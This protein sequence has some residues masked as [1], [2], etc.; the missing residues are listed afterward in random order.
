M[1]ITN[2]IL[3]QFYRDVIAQYNV[4]A[5]TI[6]LGV[7]IDL[8][9]G[10]LLNYV[11]LLFIDLTQ[12]TVTRET[13]QIII[14][15]QGSLFG[16]PQNIE[17]IGTDVNSSIG[18]T[19][20]C[21]SSGSV[22]LKTV[23]PGIAGS[24][25]TV[26]GFIQP[27]ESIFYSLQFKDAQW[28]ITNIKPSEGIFYPSKGL[29]LK[30]SASSATI[31]LLAKIITED[32]IIFSGPISYIKNEPTQLYLDSYFHRLTIDCGPLKL[33]EVHYTVRTSYYIEEPEENET[34]SL[35][36][37]IVSIGETNPIKI[38]V[39]VD[40]QLGNNRWIFFSDI[41]EGGLTLA[42]G[43]NGIAEFVGGN[44]SNFILPDSVR[45]LG[46]FGLTK[47][48][49]GIDPNNPSDVS[50]VF[51]EVGS[52][53]KWKPPIP[54]ISIEDLHVQWQI[55]NPFETESQ[56]SGGVGGSLVFGE[57]NPVHLDVFA[58]LPDFIIQANLRE[59]ETI[60]LV[61][62]VEVFFPDAGDLKQDIIIDELSILAD[63]YSQQ[64]ELQAEIKPDPSF[65]IDLIL[66]TL[67]LNYVSFNLNYD[68]NKLYG[69]LLAK[70][71][72]FDGDW[73]VSAAYVQPGNWIFSVRL[74]QG[75][76]VELIKLA[77]KFLN[78]KSDYIPQVDITELY[79]L[80]NLSDK[81]YTFEGEV[82]TYWNLKI[83]NSGP[84]ILAAISISSFIQENTTIYKGSISGALM[85][86][87][88][89][90]TAS[91]SFAPDTRIIQ[92][93]IKYKQLELI[94]SLLK[95]KVGTPEEKNFL[96][97]NFGDL[98]FG[99]IVEYLIGLA[100]PNAEFKLEAPWNVLNDV[101]FKNLS[102]TVDINTKSVSIDYAINLNLVFVNIN[103]IGLIYTKKEGKGKVD[104]KI[105]GRL[106][107][108]TYGDEN[109]ITWDLLDDPPPSVPAKES[110]LIELKYLGIGQHVAIDNPQ[111]FNNVEEV[112]GAL[113]EYMQPIENKD[114][115]PLTQQHGLKFDE[116]SHWL[117]G[118]DIKVIE[119]VSLSI[120]FN[121]PDLYGLL[122]A[123][124]GD[125]AGSLGGLKFEVLYVKVTEN[126]GVFKI[127]LRVPEAFRQLEFG[128]VS[129]TLPIIKLEIYTNGN[130][131]VDLGFPKN[132]DFSVSFCIQVFP[133]I[134]Y[135]GFYI[136]SLTGATSKRVPQINNG[137]F[138]PVIEFGF[139]LSVGVGKTFNKG[140][141]KAGLSVTVEGILE[142]CLAWFN[143]DDKSLP[144]PM[145][146]WMQGTIAIV[147]KLYGAVDFKI[148]KV[149]VSV[150]AY[151]SATLTIEVYEP[152]FIELKVGVEVRATVKVL[153]IK[154]HFSFSL[155]LETSFTIGHE[156]TPPWIVGQRIVPPSNGASLQMASTNPLPIAA[157]Q[158]QLRMQRS[159][160]IPKRKRNGR[161]LKSESV[162]N[163][164]AD[165]GMIAL[166]AMHV[167]E[168]GSLQWNTG[169]VFNAIKQV[170]LT[171][172]PGFTVA[173]PDTLLNGTGTA[174][175]VQISMAL[176]AENTIPLNAANAAE[177][178]AISTGS[179]TRATKAE[180]APFNL[181]IRGMLAYAINAL[182]RHDAALITLEDLETLYEL[183]D[184]QEA[185]NEGF[186]YDKLKTFISNNYSFEISGIPAESR[187][188]NGVTAATTSPQESSATIFPMIPELT[189]S[190]SGL[191]TPI[192][193]TDYHKVSAEYEEE[194]AAY[195]AHLSVDYLS[196][197]ATD[198]LDKSGTSSS[199]D[200]GNESLATMV[201]RDYFWMIAKS[202][203]QEAQDL[204]KTYAY[205]VLENQS[206]VD[207]AN[208]TDF[209]R[210]D[211]VYEVKL[212]DS[213][214]SIAEHYSMTDAEIQQL[215]PSII[216]PVNKLLTPPL[217]VNVLY[218]VTVEEIAVENQQHNLNIGKVLS[219]SG[220]NYQVRDG[221]SL[222]SITTKF[223]FDDGGILL[224]AQ[225]ADTIQLFQIG[226]TIQIAGLDAGNTTTYFLYTPV[227]G[228]T[229]QF[230]ASYFLTR[231]NLNTLNEEQWSWYIQTIA[232]FN[233]TVNFNYNPN[234]GEVNP[235]LP[236]TSL[237]IPK[238]YNNSKSDD[239]LSYL[240]RGMDTIELIAGYFTL[241][242]N[243]TADVTQLKIDIDGLNPGGII[244][245]TPA[246]IPAID[247]PIQGADTFHS[248]AMRFGLTLDVLATVNKDAISLL[249]PLAVLNIPTK[250]HTILA[251][252][253]LA[254]LAAN[255]NITV[256]EL[257]I[258]IEKEK[259][260]FPF[261]TAN[262][263][264]NIPNVPQLEVSTLE[265]KIVSNGHSNKI[266]AMVSRFLLHGLRLPWSPSG[267][268]TPES[269]L[270]GIYNLSGQQFPAPDVDTP[271]PF[272]I[273]FTNQSVAPWIKF[274]DSYVIQPGD[275]KVSLVAQFPDIENL[276]P[277]IDWATDLVAGWIVFTN[278]RTTPNDLELVLDASYLQAHYPST[279]FKPDFIGPNAMKLFN[280]HPRRYSLQAHLHWQTPVEIDFPDPA[281]SGTP[282]AGEP[283]IWFYP[284]SLQGKVES[285]AFGN[286][287]FEL[288]LFSPKVKDGNY[289]KVG[290]YMWASLI[291]FQIRLVADPLQTGNYLSNT[292]EL[293]GAPNMEADRLEALWTYVMDINNN[294]ADPA[295]YLLYPPNATSGNPS[296]LI[297]D[298]I[299]NEQTFLLKTNL[300]T[301]T[302]S[303]A[304][305]A[306]LT[307]G[308]PTSGDYYAN[309]NAPKVFMKYLWEG[310][311]VKEGGY[312]LHYT[313]SLNGMGF[314]SSTFNES[315][316]ATIQLA[317]IL[318]SQSKASN[319]L[320]A[321]KTFNNCAVIGDNMNPSAINIFAEAIGDH[322]LIRVASVPP[323]NVG[324]E[325][326]CFL[327]DPPPGT[328]PTAIEKTRSLFS[329]L[330]Y[331]L[332][333]NNL[334][335]AS[336][337]GL[338]VGPVEPNYSD[339][340]PEKVVSDS[341]PINTTSG[342][343]HHILPVAK[344]A[345]SHQL[346]ACVALPNPM[347]DP[348]AGIAIENGQLGEVSLGF[349]FHGI[350][351]NKTTIDPTTPLKNLSLSVGYNDTVIGLSKW[352]GLMTHYGVDGTSANPE[353]ALYF[354]FQLDNYVP[355][356]GVKY[357]KAVY[358]SS[359]HLERYKQIWYQSLQKDV[360]FQ[361]SSSLDQ[362]LNKDKIFDLDKAVFVNFINAVYTFL[363]TTQQLIG[364]V[365]QIIS[366]DV[367][368]KITKAYAVTYH[369]LAEVNAQSKAKDIFSGGI[370]IPYHLKVAREESIHIIVTLANDMAPP[371]GQELTP[372]ILVNNNL[373]VVITGKIVL[374][375]PQHDVTVNTSS[376]ETIENT[377]LKIATTLSSSV[378]S[379][380]HLNAQPV[381]PIINKGIV[382]SVEGY[383][384][385]TVEDD[386]L[387][388][389]TNQFNMFAQRGDPSVG[390]TFTLADIAVSIQEVKNLI[391]ENAILQ[392]GEYITQSG[393]TFNKIVKKNP[394]YTTAAL[395]EEKSNLE[396]LN[397]F[398]AGE[399]LHL[400]NKEQH[401]FAD[402]TLE[403]VAFTYGITTTQLLTVNPDTTLNS[404]NINPPNNPPSNLL[405]IPGLVS[406]G[407]TLGKVNYA[408]YSVKLDEDL[409][410]IASKFGMKPIDMALLNEQ[411]PYLFQP[412]KPITIE[413]ETVQTV[414]TD[415]FL[416]IINRFKDEKGKTISLQQ[417][418][419]A[420][421]SNSNL[422]T[423]HAFLAANLPKT[424]LNKSD[425]KLSVLANV[426]NVPLASIA[427]ANASLEGFLADSGSV[428]IKGKKLKLGAHDTFSSLVTRFKTEY[429][430]DTT[431]REIAEAN[432]E[433]EILSSDRSFML[434][435]VNPELNT[436][437]GFNYPENPK[438]PDTLFE[439]RVDVLMLRDMNGENL[440][441]PDFVNEDSVKF[442]HSLIAPQSSYNSTGQLTLVAFAE[443]FEAAFGNKLKIAVSKAD[444]LSPDNKP[445]R[446]IWA[447]YFGTDGVENI[448][449]DQSNPA[450]YAIRPLSTRLMSRNKV[451]I[452]EYENGELTGGAKKDFKSVDLEVWAREYLK[453]IDLFLSAPY[454]VAAYQISAVD[455][456][457]VVKAKEKLADAISEGLDYILQ[458]TPNADKLKSAQT[459]LK[460]NLLN[461]L[462]SSYDMDALL[463]YDAVVTA[464][465][466]NQSIAPRF[467]GKP[468]NKLYVTKIADTIQTI[469]TTM[470]VSTLY[471]GN[472]LQYTGRILNAGLTVK[473]VNKP[474]YIITSNDT[475]QSL[476]TKFSISMQELISGL[477]WDNPTQNGLF[478]GNRT[479]N[480][481]GVSKKVGGM[482]FEELGFYFDKSVEEVA[483]ANKDAMNIFQLGKDVKF[484]DQSVKVTDQNNSLQLIAD[485]FNNADITPKTLAE[486]NRLTKDMINVDFMMYILEL[487]PDFSI[488]TSKMPLKTG[489]NE[490]NFILNV[491]SEAEHR[492][493]LLSPDYYINELEYNI[494]NVNAAPGY[495]AS[496]WLTLI[497]PIQA[498]SQLFNNN[499]GQPEIP[500]PL[501]SYPTT[502]TIV[503]QSN[504]PSFSDGKLPLDFPENI[505][506][507]KEWDF[508]FTYQHT[509]AEQD[510]SY[511]NAFFNVENSMPSNSKNTETGN[512]T[513][514][515]LFDALAQFTTI[516]PALSADMTLMLVGK[517]DQDI[518]E[519]FLKTFAQQ[520][521]GVAGKWTYTNQRLSENTIEATTEYNYRIRFSTEEKE[522]KK[523]YKNLILNTNGEIGPSNQ[524]PVISWIDTSV[525][526]HKLYELKAEPN[527]KE[528]VYIY[529][530]EVLAFR[531]IQHKI[532]YRELDIMKYQNALGGA[533]VKRN[534]DLVEVPTQEEFIFQT[535]E[536]IFNEILVP[537][538]NHNQVIS[539]GNQ[540]MNGNLKQAL[541]VLFST[542]LENDVA[543]VKIAAK[544]GFQL[545]ATN[546]TDRGTDEE[547]VSQ[548]PITFRPVVAYSNSIPDDLNN[549]ITQWQNGKPISTQGGRYIF[550]VCVFS[551]LK[552]NGI[553]P[554]IELRNLV[555]YLSE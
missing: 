463:Q 216:D 372:E 179:L 258:D 480:I 290:L 310:F 522:N 249:A 76:K 519:K 518:M 550:D 135:G 25:H 525:S 75:S 141:L 497:I 322:D 13:Q 423:N 334:F 308:V 477:S 386:S 10:A 122:I 512:T 446:H 127:E 105:T 67:N 24:F 382:L 481:T 361:L 61:E 72:L 283:S 97:I 537:Y 292:Y 422:L 39:G 270:Y 134:G 56:Q 262:N 416:T 69:S 196:Q 44:I 343:Y 223:G 543:P 355:G 554:I 511:I 489:E 79:F 169:L 85:I 299:S 1:A 383:N 472:M 59:G 166:T 449:I 434:P 288:C 275:T 123:L 154:I 330:S 498:G 286:Q 490:L 437:L 387:Q 546:T 245:G 49:L 221:D 11:Q 81:T 306:P 375:V 138:N 267:S 194:M 349:E 376:K 118:L 62:A 281:H 15:G 14:Q 309:L 268:I 344:F 145:Y 219:I 207:I 504:Q 58:V 436:P 37:G 365:H 132:A 128:E 370:N 189:M 471:I 228:D 410:G 485:A 21:S 22:D 385:T 354:N 201:F 328:Q 232:N 115:N 4:S 408:P 451:I 547:I 441:D 289:P 91:Y 71:N 432:K 427:V 523:Y 381:L 535:P 533:Y 517:G 77:T 377:L 242:Q 23:F 55:V 126:I 391:V 174:P 98:S 254:S 450:Y 431:V 307:S 482:T 239:A 186:S 240:T 181:L 137:V 215:N 510:T 224:V 41:K 211:M 327:P 241:N 444:G 367:L 153:F 193:F 516:W 336:T 418:M 295:V 177:A 3:D 473:Y 255:F 217:L 479:I 526:P 139:G 502:P 469:A 300:S 352:P 183:L 8:E 315:G 346:P 45:S 146:Y 264:I 157:P 102:L 316:V 226:K 104:V 129:V 280:D 368:S 12:A 42:D 162:N 478:A 148:I 276:N 227:H 388:N 341:P 513:I 475:I 121:D 150:T 541:E 178:Q 168:T 133:F 200:S 110:A 63:F 456:E 545:V 188:V 271:T 112:I 305:I 351:G 225:N 402:D 538:L 229:S 326:T 435:P 248:I 528:C 89:Q 155:E 321:I 331:H 171:M 170:H 68:Q 320:R 395:L 312:H 130:F 401:P 210:I 147:G 424:S 548:L 552:N 453:A 243:P 64:Y 234:T 301:E 421:Q 236:G 192:D 420:I 191:G 116:N 466:A 2:S 404:Q 369:Q 119:T 415:S 6:K 94:A 527:G 142:G 323:G 347:D 120:V 364:G 237:K 101:N 103:T 106:L 452:Q 95:T 506:K 54:Y 20:S 380:G 458:V 238:A 84:Q 462:Y 244:I 34:S 277:Q 362:E 298:K 83:F 532:E 90:A 374:A 412:N 492:H 319:P 378:G 140:P 339:Q 496:D 28:L 48:S 253:T 419:D 454:A 269:P 29:N 257:A 389:I 439:V 287:N 429:K 455:Y 440:I 46:S 66:T 92:F 113:K 325:M 51:M 165:F 7:N 99:A 350:Y 180:D 60:S 198:P 136:A 73:N 149:D 109:P 486:K 272:E 318:D 359:A 131:K 176:L 220:I 464:N 345:T 509:E 371:Q 448:T 108:K 465:F 80:Y 337:K 164:G 476:L 324:F 74:Q 294:E 335:K 459:T 363:S 284:E 278:I 303:G 273:T 414:A 144:D 208:S 235:L 500:L 442:D 358:N 78:F 392:L 38:R 430:L 47:F 247:Y 551:T 555:F 390:D 124:S 521:D 530:E 18:L 340:H 16:K 366:L 282:I 107:D 495:Q 125:R 32:E 185:E 311:V 82:S 88:F 263:V 204:M 332:I 493:L 202:A 203:V 250:I 503:S 413:G 544:Y 356:P 484:E 214:H 302:N 19:L 218:G 508:A 357:T 403:M 317:V 260:I 87:A 411:V 507:A 373:D 152:I 360:G 53:K 151:A 499:L 409:Q 443:K 394:L 187:A 209:P 291:E 57:T 457:I 468:V 467:N 33:E 396:V 515:I 173:G 266:A 505:E 297:A 353:I 233:P 293:V 438:F 158:P 175:S 265:E 542:L 195:F 514:A 501:R 406:I 470:N 70:L 246:K 231:T 531:S 488:T 540:S 212:G 460:D 296:G 494:A 553:H 520:I 304:S 9:V 30:A 222:S 261:N 65:S 5:Q 161:I 445:S 384:Y 93:S 487:I 111:S 86:N 524:F 167:L 143:P 52:S 35:F 483:E 27:T 338:P 163:I 407:E 31:P 426:F 182:P 206:L 43:L 425:L 259:N 379:L 474:D 172:V 536:V 279:T 114:Q 397:V 399:A 491:K 213:L 428:A 251:D 156:S 256:A 529:Q 398:E 329:L 314:P 230:I 348:Y 534:V 17:L 40:I 96:K 405:N 549:V 36:S 26:D 117:F 190:Y 342:Y 159:P 100:N 393:D 285:N 333:K 400:F 197:V 252:D 50:F 274:A 539:F 433:E 447:L 461:S 160:V 205:T 184:T 313:N 417:L 199:T